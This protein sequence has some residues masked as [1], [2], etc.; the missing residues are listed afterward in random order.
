MKNQ[1]LREIN[2]IA[3]SAAIMAVCSWISIPAPV[4]FTLQTF[5]VFLTSGLFGRKKGSL[6]V[7]VYILL[8][9]IGI[10]V[11]SGGRGGPGVLFGETG[12]YIIGFLAAA[13]L[14]GG[15]CE[16]KEKSIPRLIGAMLSGLAVCYALGVLWAYFVY[17]RAEGAGLVLA[18]VK[19]VAVFIVPDLVKIL[20]AAFAV[21]A[22]CRHIK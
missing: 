18:L 16:R 11:F 5:G 19:H 2:R 20:A 22:L 4:P 13:L 17:L 12:G 1:K 6:A 21:K 7:L 15:I 9:A 14:C 8:G 3:V 10:P